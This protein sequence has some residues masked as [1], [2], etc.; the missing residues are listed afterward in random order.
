MLGDASSPLTT[1]SLPAVGGWLIPGSGAL[2]PPASPH[3]Q[4]GA[5]LS[6]SPAH[7]CERFSS[8]RNHRPGPYPSPYAHRNSSPSKSARWKDGERAAGCGR[9][10]RCRRDGA[11]GLGA[12]AAMKWGRRVRGPGLVWVGKL[13]V[14]GAAC[15]WRVG[16]P[17]AGCALCPGILGTSELG[18]ASTLFPYLSWE[19]RVLIV[20][21]W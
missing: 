2:C 3:P 21:Y 19:V 12:S 10:E 11:R 6:L 15:C 5:P 14:C 9:P 20:G 13:G 16:S 4:F 18:L 17:C 1:L 8:L 7:G